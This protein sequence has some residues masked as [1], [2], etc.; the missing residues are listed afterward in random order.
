M[1]S[2]SFGGLPVLIDFNIVLFLFPM[3]SGGAFY[4]SLSITSKLG[5]WQTVSAFLFTSPLVN[6]TGSLTSSSFFVGDSL[7]LVDL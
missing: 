5:L 7:S 1:S 2:L 4:L 3:F 6:L